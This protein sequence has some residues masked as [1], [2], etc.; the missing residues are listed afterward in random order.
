MLDVLDFVINGTGSLNLENYSNIKTT[1]SAGI[2]GTDQTSGG[3]TYGN[4]VNYIFYSGA[5][6]TTG[7]INTTVNSISI[8]NGTA[9]TLNNL[10]LTVDGSLTV[11]EGSSFGAGDVAINGTGYISVID[12]SSYTTSFITAHANGINVSIKQLQGILFIAKQQT[13]N[14]MQLVLK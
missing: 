12:N 14:L 2:A 7:L 13:T 4:A 3:S 11:N 8:E 1:N 6:Q 10:S 9:L 5:A